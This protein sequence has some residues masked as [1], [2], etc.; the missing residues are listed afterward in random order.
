MTCTQCDSAIDLT[1]TDLDLEMWAHPNW[2]E[3]AQAWSMA[4][5]AEHYGY[6]DEQ[7][8]DFI[9]EAERKSDRLMRLVMR[10]RRKRATPVRPRP[11]SRRSV[12]SAAGTPRPKRAVKTAP[13]DPESRQPPS[14]KTAT[15]NGE[16]PVG[17]ANQETH[18]VLTVEEG[19]KFLRIGVNQ[20][21]D[22]IGR[23]EVRALRI[24]RTIRLSR[25]VLVRW[26]EGSCEVAETKGHH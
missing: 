1:V 20:L 22:A 2:P 10:A 4:D 24:G 25:A 13:E 21:Y 26:L 7:V 5:N 23:G 6:S 9:R 12:R 11:C 3:V 15:H 19:A 8:T 18:D 16:A 14:Q 17:A